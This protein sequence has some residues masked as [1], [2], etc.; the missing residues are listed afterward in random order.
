MSKFFVDGKNTVSMLNVNDF[1]GHRGSAINGI[2]GA[3]GRT[4]TA[5]ATKRYK[6]KCAT[7]RTT[8]HGTAEGGVTTINHTVNVFNDGLTWM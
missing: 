2:L 1:K 3:T 5:V 6:F 8:I 4:E 7:G